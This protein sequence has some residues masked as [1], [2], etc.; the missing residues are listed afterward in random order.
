MVGF[1]RWAKRFLTS[2]ERNPAVRNLA[3]RVVRAV[4]RRR[5]KL[6]NPAEVA[7]AAPKPFVTFYDAAAARQLIFDWERDHPEDSGTHYFAT[8]AGRYAFMIE[9]IR[10]LG[11][12]GAALDVGG[13]AL[14]QAM[15]EARTPLS[16]VELSPEVD[17]EIDEWGEQAGLD[18]YQL[19]IFS[20]VIEHFNADP[21]RA[22]HEINRCLVD[23]G[24]L[25]LTT[26]NIASELGL[27]YLAHGHAPYAMAN[28]AGV[29]RNRHEREYASRELQML[30]AAHGFETWAATVNVYGPAAVKRKARAW[31]QAHLPM[32]DPAL[33][34]DT[35]IV[36]ARKVAQSPRPRWIHPIY[37]ESVSENRRDEVPDDVA[38]L[39]RD[40]HPPGL[41]DFL[42][43]Y[44]AN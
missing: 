25:L 26:V 14:T 30:V 40:G 29:R 9:I 28:I 37:H 38:T 17:L 41:E 13:I 15:Y 42:A 18:R 21:A 32:P 1:L 35:N 11:V 33:H 4:Y 24:Y 39:M 34:G 23:G 16:K 3:N 31:V 2:E 12:T 5:A 36:I 43:A 27:Y 6:A 20:E 10:R 19:V 8:H 22:L 44:V 7:P